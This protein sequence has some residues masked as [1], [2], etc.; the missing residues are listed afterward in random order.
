RDGRPL[1]AATSS[2]TT[3][4]AAGAWR[5]TPAAPG[6]ARGAAV[7]LRDLGALEDDLDRRVVVARSITPA[8]LVQIV[9]AAALICEQGGALDHAAAMARELGLP[10]V[11][12]C[13]SSVRAIAV[14]DELLV[15][16]DGGLVVRLGGP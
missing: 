16:G 4:L 1:V 6:T 12:G 14:G 9:G 2:T 13:G 8:T 10:C 7:H 3:A 5:G 11:V 15:D